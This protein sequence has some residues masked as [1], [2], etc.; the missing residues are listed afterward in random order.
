MAGTLP[1]AADVNNLVGAICRDVDMLFDRV[2]IMQGWLVGVD[3][4]AAPYS[5][6]TADNA[7]IKSAFTDLFQLRQIYMG[8][9]TLA[10]AKDFTAFAKQLHGPSL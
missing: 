8:N 7:L 2:A 4:T 6:T 5:M 10:S 3:L 1:S 9:A